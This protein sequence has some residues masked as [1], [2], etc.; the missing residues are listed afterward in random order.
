MRASALLSFVTIRH[1]RCALNVIDFAELQIVGI[2][3]MKCQ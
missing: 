1:F 2:L 3:S